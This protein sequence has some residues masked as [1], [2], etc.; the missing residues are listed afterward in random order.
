MVERKNQLYR[1]S[2]LTTDERGLAVTPKFAQLQLMALL[3]LTVDAIILIDEQ[4]LITLFNAG[5]ERIFGY[6]SA[7]SLGQ[8][9]DRLLP[10][11]MRRRHAEHIRQFG[12]SAK[13]ALVMGAAAA[14]N[15]LQ[16][17]LSAAKTC[18][19]TR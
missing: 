3:N 8:P 9:L 7:D 18:D 4:H 14:P 2:S 1:R 10:E 6:R 11:R 5:A 13:T 15:S 19:T 17:N 12:V 16:M